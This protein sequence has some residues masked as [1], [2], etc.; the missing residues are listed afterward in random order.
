MPLVLADRVVNLRCVHRAWRV[1]LIQ[2]YPGD[3]EI[4]VRQYRSVI[5]L[6]ALG[7]CAGVE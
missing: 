2:E 5:R 7:E 3:D 4:I 1:S 6:S